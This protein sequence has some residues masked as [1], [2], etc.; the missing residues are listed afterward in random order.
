MGDP[1]SFSASCQLNCAER[2]AGSARRLEGAVGTVRVGGGVTTVPPVFVKRRRF[3]VPLGRDVKRLPVAMDF[4]WLSIFAGERKPFAKR[5]TAAPATCGEAIDVPL[6]E[7][8]A[9]SEVYQAEV[10]ELPGAMRST[11]LP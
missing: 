8:L 11:Q 7:A 2:L 6:S 3:G 1:P 9:P 4:N 10:I 5:V